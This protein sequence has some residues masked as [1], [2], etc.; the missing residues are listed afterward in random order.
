MND[1]SR[2]EPTIGW[3][4]I[5]RAAERIAPHVHRTP[6]VRC[7]SLDRMSGASL[8][9]K[10]ENLQKTGSFKARGALH[11][12]LSLAPEEA[13]RGVVTHSSGNHGQALAWAA[14]QA[15]VAATVVMPRDASRVKRAAVEGYGAEVVLCEPTLAA[16]EQTARQMVAERGGR[17]VHPYD[18]RQIVAGQATA[19]LELLE[20]AG[21]LD[22]V[23][24]PV[25]GGGLLSGTALVVA[26][27]AQGACTVVGA[28][29]AAADDACRSLCAGRLIRPIRTETIADGLRTALGRLPFSII[30]HHVERIVTVDEEQIVRAMRCV[31]SRM[32]LV[33]EPSAAVA[34]AAVL[35]QPEAWHGRR[36]GVILSGGNVD[37]DRLPWLTPDAI[38]PA[39]PPT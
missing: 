29:P 21:P 28:E 16:R 14:R 33:I 34:V 17:L 3:A 22:Y 37:L 18:D 8:F 5:E 39:T 15:G 1:S 11:A 35:K 26:H 12:V 19:A 24:A 20:A 25:G 38:R 6:V 27:R 23:V 31:W 10:C 2:D 4:E 13:S 9:F 36:V 7:A 30:R 32:K